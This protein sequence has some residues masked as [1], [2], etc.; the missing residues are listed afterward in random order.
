[1][2]VCYLWILVCF[3]TA[4]SAFKNSGN[5]R[6]TLLLG[7]GAFAY[8]LS[9][10]IS[11]IVSYNVPHNLRC[12]LLNFVDSLSGYGH[13]FFELYICIRSFLISHNVQNRMIRVAI[14]AISIAILVFSINVDLLLA[15]MGNCNFM[16]DLT[17]YIY[18][19]FLV[20]LFWITLRRV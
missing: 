14:I 4:V 15:A 18:N 8:V 11:L 1:M 9:I 16:V 2:N 13:V 6:K 3:L 10:N 5:L 19:F 17:N 12:Q 20:F 7:G